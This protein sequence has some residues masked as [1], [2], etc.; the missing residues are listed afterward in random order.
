MIEEDAVLYKRVGPALIKM[1]KND[2]ESEVGG[3]LEFLQKRL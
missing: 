3:R 2:I 1:S